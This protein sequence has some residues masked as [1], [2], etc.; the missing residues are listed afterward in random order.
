[1]LRSERGRGSERPTACRVDS[2]RTTSERTGSCTVGAE[3]RVIVAF[4]PVPARY[5]RVRVVRE[6]QSES[7][8]TNRETSATWLASVCATIS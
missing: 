8:R 2:Y 7:I 3:M 5:D 1:M 4:A 6:P